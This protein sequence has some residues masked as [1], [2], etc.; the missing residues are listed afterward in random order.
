LP[1][2]SAAVSKILHA[3]EKSKSDDISPEE[4][5]KAIQQLAAANHS[6]VDED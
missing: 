5:A 3:L 4:V 2:D 1:A 6:V